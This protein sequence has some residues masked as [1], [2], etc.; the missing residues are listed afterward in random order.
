MGLF[1]VLHGCGNE[2]LNTFSRIEMKASKYGT[3]SVGAVRVTDYSNSEL[4]SARKTLQGSLETMR[5]DL[6]VH[7]NEPE[8][9]GGYQISRSY[10][11]MC[12]DL[13][14]RERLKS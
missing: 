6:L 14:L 3:V 7:L 1:L 12:L 2:T 9:P 5:D 4:Q 13:G 8:A 11:K 10:M